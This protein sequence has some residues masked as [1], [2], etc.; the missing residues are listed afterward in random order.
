MKKHDVLKL[1]FDDEFATYFKIGRSNYREEGADVVL[2]S[3]ALCFTTI[4]S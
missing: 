2:I 4:L 1:P 3:K